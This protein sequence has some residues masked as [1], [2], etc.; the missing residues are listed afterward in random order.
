MLTK[1]YQTID[2]KLRTFNRFIRIS[3]NTTAIQYAYLINFQ[4]SHYHV[5]HGTK[6]TV[7]TK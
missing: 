6:M 3:N 2:F 4:I 5:N 7:V 1:N